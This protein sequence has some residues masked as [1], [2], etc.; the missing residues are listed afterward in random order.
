MVFTNIP[1]TQVVL[2]L[3]AF[4]TLLVVLISKVWSSATKQE[5]LRKDVELILTNH[6]PHIQEEL[7][8]L[9]E[10]IDRLLEQ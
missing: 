7:E 9:N 2:A 8:K 3:C 6:L 5:A 4:I 10:K 1:W